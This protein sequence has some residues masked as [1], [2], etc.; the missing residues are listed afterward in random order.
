[1]FSDRG[2]AFSVVSGTASSAIMYLPE[3]H[4]AL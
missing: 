3:R 1:M 2:I 4:G